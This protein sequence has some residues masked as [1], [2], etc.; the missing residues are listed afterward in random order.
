MPLKTV[1]KV[2]N[3]SN[4]SDA[5]YCSGMGVDMLGFSVVEGQP[6]YISPKLFQEIR[7]WISGPKVVAQI[8][9]LT[10][11]SHLW[12]IIQNYAPEYLELSSAAYFELKSALNLPCIVDGDE[13]TISN[14]SERDN[15]KYIQLSDPDIIKGSTY[16]ILLKNVSADDLLKKI[17]DKRIAGISLSGNAEIRPGFKNYEDLAEILELLD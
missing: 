9:G 6:H 16:P 14:I 2:S 1:V 11:S 10:S 4:L 15:I 7:G 12:D 3:I 8:Y 13:Q 17:A 5:R